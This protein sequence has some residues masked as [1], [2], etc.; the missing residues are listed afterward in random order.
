MLAN[1]KPALK[2]MFTLNILGAFPVLQSV[3]QSVCS[4][5]Q[6]IKEINTTL[7]IK[8]NNLILRFLLKQYPYSWFKISIDGLCKYEALILNTICSN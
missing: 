1:Y 6:E 2:K 4:H 5:F 7:K 8:E 3:L